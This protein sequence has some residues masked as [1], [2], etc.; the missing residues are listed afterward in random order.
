MVNVVLRWHL[1]YLSELLRHKW[2]VVLEGRELNVPL[3]QLILHDWSK[4]LPDEWFPAVRYLSTGEASHASL[5]KHHRR[6][7]H[8]PQWWLAD[9]DGRRE[10]RPMP[11]LFRREMLAD[12]RAVGR[13]GGGDAR[14]W[15]LEYGHRHPLHPETRAWVE[16]QLRP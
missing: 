7:R 9:R 12:W 10:P 8:H 2:L 13:A 14:A 16:A 15:Y 5:K 1:T 4:F 3:P 6:N 11:D